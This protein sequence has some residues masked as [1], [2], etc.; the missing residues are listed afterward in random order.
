M[1]NF[2]WKNNCSCGCIWS[3]SEVFCG[4]SANESVAKS[5]YRFGSRFFTRWDSFAGIFPKAHPTN[6]AWTVIFPEIIFT[7]S[8]SIERGKRLKI[9]SFFKRLWNL[10]KLKKNPKNPLSLHCCDHSVFIFRFRFTKVLDSRKSKIIQSYI[11]FI[12][13]R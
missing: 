9:C 13:W 5:F 7:I 1:Y 4:R 6:V 12:F 3:V 8:I 2:H 10:C 11:H